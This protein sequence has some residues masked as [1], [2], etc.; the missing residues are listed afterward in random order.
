MQ[1]NKLYQNAIRRPCRHPR[2]FLNT[3]FFKPANGVAPLLNEGSSTT[4]MYA[5][6]LR[7]YKEREEIMKLV[8]TDWKG[9]SFAISN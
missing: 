6:L 2:C 4:D 5:G 7:L 3:H 9:I 8:E 1:D